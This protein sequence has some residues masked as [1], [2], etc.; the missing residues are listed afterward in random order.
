MANRIAHT[1]LARRGEGAEPVVLL[2]D[3]NAPLLATI[4]GVLKAGKTYVPL[5]PSL[6]PARMSALLE[7]IQSAC[8]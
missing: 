3:P 4:L 7:D 1:I 6:P 2:F 5:D 8:I